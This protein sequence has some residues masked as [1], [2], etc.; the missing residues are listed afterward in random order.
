MFVNDGFSQ[1]TSPKADQWQSV[2]GQLI[3]SGNH[4]F[5]NIWY[6]STRYAHGNGK[7]WKNNSQP[8]NT[9]A[10]HTLEQVLT[11][12]R[13]NKGQVSV[14][15][16]GFL[17]AF[18]K[19]KKGY[20]SALL[21][22]PDTGVIH[23]TASLG[24][25]ELLKGSDGEW[26]WYYGDRVI[27]FDPSKPN[28]GWVAADKIVNLD[29][30]VNNTEGSFGI[31]GSGYAAPKGIEYEFWFFPRAGGRVLSGNSGKPEPGVLYYTEKDCY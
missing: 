9:P 7:Y 5:T 4:D 24:H 28:S 30:W 14:Q 19:T 21:K 2:G 1:S 13:I 6:A 29:V 18:I 31:W 25:M 27:E 20:S 16:P 15:G 11:D 17:A 3:A 26:H 23:S 12:V 22:D 8:G 10:T